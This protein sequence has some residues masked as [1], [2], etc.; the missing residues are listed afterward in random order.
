MN[1]LRRPLDGI[2]VLDLSKWVSGPYCTSI[3]ADMGA[4]VIEVEPPGGAEGRDGGGP[5]HNGVR[6]TWHF[7]HRNKKNVT[8]NLRDET[9]KSVL[10]DLIRQTDVVVENFRPGTIER[11]GFGYR[12]LQEIK[13][14]IIL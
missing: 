11:M 6:V 13:P 14:D 3:L 1:D 10:R 9:G 4:E 2:R 8:L 5:R 7:Y 12:A